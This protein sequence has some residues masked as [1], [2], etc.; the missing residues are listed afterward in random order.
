VA[1]HRVFGGGHGFG[2]AAVNAVIDVFLD[3]NLK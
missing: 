1:M 3:Y 2:C